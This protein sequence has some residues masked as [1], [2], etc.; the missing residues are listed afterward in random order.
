ME[1]K[2]VFK[3]NGGDDDYKTAKQ[4]SVTAFSDIWNYF[5]DWPLGTRFPLE[6]R[7][8]KNVFC[9]VITPLKWPPT[10]NKPDNKNKLKI[11][12]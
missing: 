3:I 10:D 2:D 11:T 5:L 4:L 9:H 7:T 1:E 8:N 12:Q 6:T